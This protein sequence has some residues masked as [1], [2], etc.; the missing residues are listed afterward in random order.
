[1]FFFLLDTTDDECHFVNSGTLH[2]QY[3]IYVQMYVM[4]N[5]QYI[6]D[7]ALAVLLNPGT[8]KSK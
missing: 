8:S 3:T 5:V 6:F 1:M 7:L 4:G 2:V